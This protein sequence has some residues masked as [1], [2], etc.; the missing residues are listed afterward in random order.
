MADPL[1]TYVFEDVSADFIQLKNLNLLVY[2]DR[3]SDWPVIQKKPVRVQDPTSKLWYQIGEVVAVGQSR[4]YRIKFISGS[5]LWRKRRF[6][7]HDFGGG[8]RRSH[9]TRRDVFGNELTTH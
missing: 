3:L 9:C 5:V 2:A 4:L 8:D 6:I 1:P 7:R